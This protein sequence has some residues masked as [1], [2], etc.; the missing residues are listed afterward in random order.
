MARILSRVGISYQIGVVGLIGIIGLIAVGIIDAAGS[1]ELA[2]AGRALDRSNAAIRILAELH[3]DIF[4]ARTAEK[5][6]LLYRKEQYIER[7]AKALLAFTKAADQLGRLIGDDG[8]ADL[9]KISSA[10]GRYRVQFDD[11]VASARRIGLDENGGLNGKLRGS[12]HEIEA[13]IDAH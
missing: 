7:H 12:V 4:E 5:D 1:R 9:E 11:V 6:F 8:K 2:D 3:V 10:I 13:M